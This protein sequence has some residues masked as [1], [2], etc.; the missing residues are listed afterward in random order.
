MLADVAPFS[1]PAKDGSSLVT[2]AASLDA[3]FSRLSI[4]TR[5][6]LHVDFAGDL[7]IT[8]VFWIMFQKIFGGTFGQTGRK[9]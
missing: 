1:P 5:Y 3:P 7:G 9:L 2:G 6:L 8:F 4:I